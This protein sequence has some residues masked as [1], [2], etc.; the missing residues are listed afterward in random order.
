MKATKTYIED[1]AG[2]ITQNFGAN[3]D[4]LYNGQ[5]LK[6]HTG[7]DEVLGFGTPIQAYFPMKVYKVLTRE[8]PAYDGTGFTGVFGIVD[9][10]MQTF[11]ILYGHC[12]PTV[13]EGDVINVGDVIGTEANHGQIFS[14]GQQ[15]TLA[16][17]QA[18]DQRGSHRHIQKRPVRK[19]LKTAYAGLYLDYGPNRE[20]YF[21]G[22]NYFE[23]I[24]WFNG[25][26]GCVDVTLPIFTRNLGL[27]SHG[28]DVK[29]LQAFLGVSQTGFYWLATRL[30]V[31]EYQVQHEI[32]PTGFCGPLT[33]ASLNT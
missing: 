3:A 22:T 12:D 9:T 8:R 14:G 25:Y 33:R 11:E 18:G 15:I 23:Y 32:T 28:D 21:D 4:P 13:K 26:N 19:V 10:P 29:N 1:F 24:N 20:A 2:W 27:W 5:G 6:G 7:T 31:M 16:M 30:A 17:Q